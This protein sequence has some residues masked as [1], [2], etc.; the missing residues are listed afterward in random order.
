MATERLSDVVHGAFDLFGFEY[1]RTR[2]GHR[3]LTAGAFFALIL[4]C[5]LTGYL[6][7][8]VPSVDPRQPT[9]PQRI[10]LPSPQPVG[11]FRLE[12]VGSTN[13]VYTRERLVGQWTLMYFGYS[14]CPDVC[15]PTLEVLAEVAHALRAARDRAAEL[16]LVFVTVDPARDSREALRAYLS[17]TSTDVI[18]L[19]G[20]DAQIAA[21][22]A[23]LGLMHAPGDAD[24]AG[25]YLVD[26]PATILLIDPDARLRAGFPLP[27]DPGNIVARVLSIEQDFVRE[28]VD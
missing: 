14:H 9:D 21:L 26:H 10:E 5:F 1:E 25:N 12:E 15:R 7:V 17:R 4:G 20:S 24:D 8:P 19:R 2:G 13:G 3:L 18:G 23:R 16:E 6:L 28:R 27:H 22:A 11:E